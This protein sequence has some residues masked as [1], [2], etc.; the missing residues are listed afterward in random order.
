MFLSIQQIRQSLEHLEAVHPFYGITFLVFKKHNLPIGQPSEF[1]SDAEDK[2]F[3][4]RYYKPDKDS[5]WYYRVF[6]VSIKSKRWL[7]P[8]YASSTLQSIKTRQ[9]RGALIHTT[10]TH[11]WGWQPDYVEKLR[12][13]LYPQRRIPAFHLAVWLYREREWPSGT[14]AQNIITT[15]LKEFSI[16]DAEARELFDVSVPVDLEHGLLFQDKRVSWEELQE[17][18][19]KPPDAPL[20]EG[21]TLAYLEIQGI[22]PA[23]KLFFEPAERLNLITGDNGLGKS[24]LLECAWWALTGQWAELPA[25][26]RQEARSDEPRITFKISGDSRS[27]E[28]TTVP[29]DRQT[30]SWPSPKGRPT[31]PGLLIYARV[32]GSFAVWD[33]AKNYWS[34]TLGEDS[35][36]PRSF[37][38]TR[39][40]VWDGF[41]E[42]VGGKTSAYIN[43]LLRDWISWQN[44]PEKY[45]FKTFKKVLHRLSPP[46]GSDLGPLEPGEPVRLPFDAREMPTLKHPYGQV[47]IVHAA[48]GVRRIVTIAYL[49]VWAWEEHK[50]HSEF[51]RKEPQRRMVVLVD[52]MEAHL[53][54]HWQRAVLP[55]LLD[56]GEDLASDLRVQFLIAT[57]SP[58]VTASVEP[59]FD[60]KVDKLFHLD[61]VKTDFFTSEVRLEE[62]PFI[63]HGLVD[64]WLTSDVFELSQARSLEA[65]EAIKDAKALQLQNKPEAEEVQNVSKRLTKYLAA[66][67]EFWPRWIFFAEKHGYAP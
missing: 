29:Y 55:A 35:T 17:I 10:G 27:V 60:N 25:Y 48:A 21:G 38:F 14:I 65:E 45:P 40:Q 3:L 5:K 31:I 8:D 57:H 16:T 18:T 58:L 54:P 20:E 1:P 47:P 66:D 9:F 62:L 32:D 52:E 4:E 30:Q 41:E 46:S 37:V 56:V 44:K 22:G 51:I 2:A 13:R 19:G 36:T 61:L 23:E 12:S 39:E 53:H 49:L 11:S 43:G 63:R 26:P 50:V 28:R 15:F 34:L 67:D 6:R 64:S 7:P 59:R 24:F 33:P 42:K